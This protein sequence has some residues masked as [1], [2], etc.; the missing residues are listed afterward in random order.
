MGMLRSRARARARTLYALM[1]EAEAS[2]VA[3][4]VD[5]LRYPLI[6]FTT[7]PDRDAAGSSAIAFLKGCGWLNGMVRGVKRIASDLTRIADPVL[8]EAASTAFAGSYAII[9]DDEPITN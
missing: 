9:A 4:R 2:G 1:I 7:A 3:D 6:V 8:H 5:G